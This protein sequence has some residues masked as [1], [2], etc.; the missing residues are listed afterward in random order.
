MHPG[1]GASPAQSVWDPVP[2]DVSRGACVRLNQEQGPST[3]P[4]VPQ[5]PSPGVWLARGHHPIQNN[6]QPSFCLK[7][8][9]VC[10][11]ARE[12]GG[13]WG[14]GWGG[15]AHPCSENPGGL[16]PWACGRAWASLQ[17]CDLLHPASPLSSCPFCPQEASRSR[18]VSHL[19]G[20]QGLCDPCSQPS[21]DGWGGESSR[22]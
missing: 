11:V 17:G 2:G 12:Q 19:T 8:K 7:W 10:K 15:F 4:R 14:V 18:D 20:S 13:C 6:L 5:T 3:V 21:R 22:R 9:V 1:L 16:A